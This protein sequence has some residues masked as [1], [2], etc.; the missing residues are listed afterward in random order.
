MWPKFALAIQTCPSTTMMSWLVYPPTCPV[1]DMSI[2]YDATATITTKG[3]GTVVV[4]CAQ[5]NCIYPCPNAINQVYLVPWARSNLLPFDYLLH[6]SAVYSNAHL[7]ARAHWQCLLYPGESVLF[8]G[9]P[10]GWHECIHRR[11]YKW[12]QSPG[13]QCRVMIASADCCSIPPTTTFCPYWLSDN[14]DTPTT[15][16]TYHRHIVEG[17]LTESFVD[18][19][20]FELLQSFVFQCRK[21]K[22]VSVVQ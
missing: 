11:G 3:D 17:I 5:C 13:A 6:L 12:A 8:H 18:W 15:C 9:A 16:T 7:F 21:L 4:C 20:G 10:I 22:T 19:Y 1:R 2:P 14:W